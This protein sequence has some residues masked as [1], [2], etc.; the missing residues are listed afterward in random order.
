[1][2]EVEGY[3]SLVEI[4]NGVGY[5]SLVEIFNHWGCRLLFPS[6]EI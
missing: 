5:Y 2:V 6:G 4:F 1:M 3:Y